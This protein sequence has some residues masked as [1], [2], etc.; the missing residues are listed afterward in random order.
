MIGALP[1]TG[2]FYLYMYPRIADYDNCCGLDENRIG[3]IV[4]FLRDEVEERFLKILFLS[5]CP[6]Q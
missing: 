6:L 1:V 2:G 4:C 3:I 5:Y